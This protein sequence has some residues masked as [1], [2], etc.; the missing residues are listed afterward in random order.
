[1]NYEPNTRHWEPGDYVIHDCDAKAAYMLMVVVRYTPDGLVV[2]R[3]H[4]TD[5]RVHTGRRRSKLWRN[6][7][8]YLHDP[9]RFNIPVP[10]QPQLPEVP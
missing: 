2:T 4:D 9:A 1:M 10:G 3:Y 8:K 5:H 6:D 7:P